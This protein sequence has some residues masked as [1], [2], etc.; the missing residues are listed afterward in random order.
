MTSTIPLVIWIIIYT[1]FYNI[2]V[3]V[4][5][6]IGSLYILS[7]TKEAINILVDIIKTD[8]VCEQLVLTNV[9]K[10]K[11]EFLDV[12]KY[13]ELEFQNKEDL[14]MKTTELL[15][16]EPRTLVNVCYLKRSKLILTIGKAQ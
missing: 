14:I 13:Y 9:R 10:K 15:S 11:F 16:V 12:G 4:L 7:F 2:I 6:C 1:K 3:I 8:Y 5:C